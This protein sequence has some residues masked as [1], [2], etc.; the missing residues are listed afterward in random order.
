M[1][2]VEIKENAFQPL[3]PLHHI[4]ELKGVLEA[5]NDSHLLLLLYTWWSSSLTEIYICANIL[6]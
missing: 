6:N 1:V 4:T 2:F 3:S 5:V